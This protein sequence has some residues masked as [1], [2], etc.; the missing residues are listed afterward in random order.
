MGQRCVDPLARAGAGGRRSAPVALATTRGRG[1]RCRTPWRTARP[2]SRR[3]SS[4]AT[5]LRGR[6]PATASSSRRRHESL[7]V[8]SPSRTRSRHVHRAEARR[9]DPRRRPAGRIGA[10]PNGH[11]PAGHSRAANASGTRSPGRFDRCTL[12]DRACSSGRSS[13]RRPLRGRTV[14]GARVATGDGEDHFARWLDHSGIS[15]SLSRPCKHSLQVGHCRPGPRAIRSTSGV[16]A[17]PRQPMRGSKPS[18]QKL[19]AS[20]FARQES[21]GQ[22]TR[23]LSSKYS[24]NRSIASPGCGSDQRCESAGRPL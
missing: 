4:D 14:P 10:L 15:S 1:R 24:L 3:D 19:T 13:S 5:R 22:L 9:A 17:R 12:P 6:W 8:H 16:T 11:T 23:R 7:R 20:R 21:P 2:P 18:G